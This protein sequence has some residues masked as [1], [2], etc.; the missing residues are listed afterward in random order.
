MGIL[1][2]I[3]MKQTS[4]P[5]RKEAR[6][7]DC[8]DLTSLYADDDEWEADLK[9]FSALKARIPEMTAAFCGTPA[10]G[11]KPTVDALRRCLEFYRSASQKLEKLYVY[12]HLKQSADEGDPENIG[13]TGRVLMANSAFEAEFSWFIP[14]VQN[15]PE[16]EI[17]RMIRQI[18]DG[19]TQ[20]GVW[21]EKLIRER[22]H[23]LGE[24]EE[25][26]LAFMQ[27]SARTPQ[28]T[29][30]ILTNTDM[31][32]GTI[33]TDGESVPL[34][35][36]T[37]PKLMENP[38]RETRKTAYTRFYANFSE[39]QRTIASL[40]AGSVNQDVAYA[41][42]RGYPSARAAALFP[43]NVDES[44][45]DN[46]VAVVS[47]NLAP[48]HKYY[49]LRK[50]A[51]GLKELRH[52][53]V[54]VPL[55]KEVKR[56][57]SYEQAV[58][59]VKNA[60]SPL[61]DEYTETLANGLLGGWVDRYENRGKRSGAFSS[62]AYTGYPYILLNYKDD[63]LRDVFTLAHEGGHSMHS[64]YSAKHNPF[65]SYSYTIFEA[66]VASTFNEDLVFRY[67]SKR[68]DSPDMKAFLLCHR[69]AD[70]VATLYRQTMFAEYEHK[71]HVLVEQGTPLTAELLRSE[72]RA[73]LEKYFGPEMVFENESDLEGLRIPHFYN[74][75]YVYKYATGI[76]AALALAERVCAGGERERNDYFRFLQSGG[77][78]YPIESLRIAGVDMSAPDPV[79]AACDTFA[80]LVDEM[81]EILP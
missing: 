51:L 67:L 40:Y 77:S 66:E 78:R 9:A 3:Q 54:Y 18:P 33:E 4:I 20:Y 64:W 72:Y 26:I 63:V 68:S 69:V 48:L 25:K 75:Y 70:I 62:G 73:L 42:I 29:F 16:D 19:E 59:I 13:R 49:S 22:P 56:R 15:I 27:E 36:T 52:Y 76:S 60:L 1:Y 57:T 34:T 5:S 80:K 8:W 47:E 28:N 58:E 30:S 43:D 46:L 12:A 23:I 74:A 38:S 10:G 11:G 65:L 81:E 37:W 71:A 2:S 50:K 32:F 17:R 61:G 45:Y 7:A 6:P 35:Q 31:N 14:A 53:D 21:S 79:K 41:R 55:V 44:V 24:K 39:H